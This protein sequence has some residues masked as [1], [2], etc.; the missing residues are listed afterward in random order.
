MTDKPRIRLH[1]CYGGSRYWTCK[2]SK[3]Y[4]GIGTTPLG[5]WKD[6][7]YINYIPYARY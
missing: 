7:M 5:A 1:V 2:A 4:P 3:G 6:W